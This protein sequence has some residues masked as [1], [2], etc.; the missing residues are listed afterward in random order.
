MNKECD[1]SGYAA[2]DAICNG[3]AVHCGH[4]RLV[5]VSKDYKGP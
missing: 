5:V 1:L 4:R 2:Y 3:T